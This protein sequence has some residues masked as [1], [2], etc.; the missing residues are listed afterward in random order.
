MEF[1]NFNSQFQVL[2][3]TRYKYAIFSSRFTT[4]LKSFHKEK[5]NSGREASVCEPLE[6]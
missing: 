4:H 5:N 6:E 1:L 3:C 2:I